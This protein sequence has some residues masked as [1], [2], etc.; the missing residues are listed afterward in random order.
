MGTD[1]A[2]IVGHLA[3]PD[4]R[5]VLAALILGASTAD[6]V[7]RA[8]GLGTRPVMTSLT[9]LVDSELVLHDEDGRYWLVE[10]AFRQAVIDAQ[11]APPADEHAGVSADTARVLRAFV[12]D[13][14][15]VSIPA[16]RAKRLVVLD[17]IV[18]DFEPG[19]RYPERK[20]NA[21]LR[22]WH[23]DTAA[24]RRYLVDEGLLDREAGEYWR[25]GGSF[26]I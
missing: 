1:A 3:H 9:R 5:R 26:D 13:G 23:D 2:G 10:E 21:M 25:S 18:Q 7:K 15:L 6:D 8:T 11:A 20:V 16:P 4:R 24:L 12:R 19:R 14:R 17:L 22:K